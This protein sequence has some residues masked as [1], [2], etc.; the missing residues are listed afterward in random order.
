VEHLEC[1]N[2][3]G[4]IT[5]G[6]CNFHLTLANIRTHTRSAAHQNNIS[7]IYVFGPIGDNFIHILNGLVSVE[8]VCVCARARALISLI[9]YLKKIQH[10]PAHLALSLVACL[11]ARLRVLLLFCC[12]SELPCCCLLLPG[13]NQSGWATQSWM[14]ECLH[15]AASLKI[16]KGEPSPSLSASFV[17][18]V[19]IFSRRPNE[20]PH[21]K[22]A[23][24]PP[25]GMIF[26][27]S[28]I[29]IR[30]LMRRNKF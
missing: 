5:G 19:R 17:C 23:Q 28:K 10:S 24:E 2:K 30:K 9:Y 21:F 7:H 25:V 13:H 22:L 4:Q 12:E 6:A 16:K 14:R 3:Y 26:E 8:H 20:P 18:C 11:P 29:W 15:Q 27:F 1:L